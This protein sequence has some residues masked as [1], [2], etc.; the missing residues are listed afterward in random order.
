MPHLLMF[1]SVTV[2][3][4]IIMGLSKLNHGLR[5]VR[6]EECSG[7]IQFI[8]RIFLVGMFQHYDNGI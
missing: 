3:Y 2:L 7:N 6:G 8:L 1:T 5:G 4:Y